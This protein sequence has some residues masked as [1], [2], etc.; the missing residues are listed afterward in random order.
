MRLLRPFLTVALAALTTVPVLTA[1]GGATAA[2]AAEDYPG[3]EVTRWDATYV[4]D[5]NGSVAVTT[6]IDFDFGDS[7]GH[8]VIFTFPTTQGI[9]DSDL[10]RVWDIG[11]I[12]ATSPTGAPAAVATEMQ[13]DTLY[14][15]IGDEDISD[16]SGLQ[17]YVLSYTVG[18]VMNATT[19]SETDGD[20]AGDEFYWNAIGTGWETPVSDITVTVESPVAATAVRCFAGP[21]GSTGGCSAGEPGT[22]VTYTADAVEPYEPL[23][24]AAL[25]PAGSFDTTPKTQVANDVAR[26]FAINVWTVGVALLILVGGIW[27]V[28]RR[29]RRTGTDMVYAGVAPGLEPL[30][31]AEAAVMRRDPRAPIAVQFEP[32]RGLRPG[33]LGTLL[34]EKADVRDV[35]AT[36]VDQAV[37][38]YLRIDPVGQ[39]QPPADYRLVKLREADAEMPPYGRMLFES[40]FEGRSEV[41]FEDLKTTFAADLAKVQEEMY[42]DVTD[43]G[44]FRRNPK[45]ARGSWAAMAIVLLFVGVAATFVLAAMWGAGFVGVAIGLVG[46]VMLVLTNK[47]P[48]RTPEGSRV[49][50]Q[51]EGFKLYLAT[52]DGAQLRFEEGNDIFSRY[53]PY[54]I[55][56]GVAERWADVFARLAREGHDVPAPD[57]YGGA[58][59]AGS[60]WLYHAA[61]GR[62]MTDLT[63]LADAAISTPTPGSSGGSGFSTGGGFSGGGSF[64]GGGGGW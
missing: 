23:S 15:R 42:R 40:I 18:H 3:R 58:S 1:T 26:A 16:V 48:A 7:P 32:P 38:G 5:P 59:Y 63:S 60:F 28:M 22:S 44:W 46:L 51:T 45:S 52:A 37:R 2:S 57:W 39:E 24:V 14:V 17:T 64:G 55:A 49:L 62:Q 4:L 31:D 20:L 35:T 25:Y 21:E 12:E 10:E 9:A 13:G 27:L 11:D 33:Q 61:F 56:F 47:A 36:I 54:A 43:R 8:G 30:S 41:T 50:A 6:E 29:L 53:L 34:D 19:S